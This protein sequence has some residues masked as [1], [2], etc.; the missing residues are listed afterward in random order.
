[1]TLFA[2]AVGEDESVF[3]HALDRYCDGHMDERTVA[4][5]QTGAG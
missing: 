3:R 2:L 5:C 1:M 4:L